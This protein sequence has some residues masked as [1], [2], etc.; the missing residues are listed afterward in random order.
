VFLNYLHLNA[1]FIKTK[2]RP[3]SFDFR[4]EINKSELK[5]I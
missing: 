2:I 3:N 1:E 5:L 4:I